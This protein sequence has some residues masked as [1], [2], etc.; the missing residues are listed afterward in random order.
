MFRSLAMLA[1]RCEA[2][3]VFQETRVPFFTPSAQA[4]IS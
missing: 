3:P 2:L 1:A 4:P